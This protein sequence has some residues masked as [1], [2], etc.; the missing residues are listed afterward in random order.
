MGMVD[1]FDL[2]RGPTIPRRK[3]YYKSNEVR[4]D[5]KRNSNLISLF[6]ITAFAY[7]VGIQKAISTCYQTKW[8]WLC[9]SSFLCIS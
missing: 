5:L 6:L 1:L 9:T 8:T 7:F 4:L 2:G 3:R